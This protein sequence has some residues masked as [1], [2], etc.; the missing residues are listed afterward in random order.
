MSLEVEEIEQEERMKGFDWDLWRRVLAYA[1]PYR[2]S[3]GIMIV[4]GLGL[5]AMESGL[6]YVTKCIIDN[7]L[8]E[9]DVDAHLGYCAIY[10]GVFI[11]VAAIVFLFIWMAGRAATG[12]AHDIRE[13]SF[14]KLQELSFSYFDERPVGW[15]MARLTSDSQRLASILPW[16]CL[17]IAWGTVYILAIVGWMLYLNWILAL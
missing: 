16:F 13:A 15:M 10:A 14:D 11:G 17:D 9:G 6:P 5:A 7:A 1:R 8:G 12:V 4:S 2:R 3:L